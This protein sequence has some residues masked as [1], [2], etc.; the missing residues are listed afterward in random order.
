M[1]RYNECKTAHMEGYEN[2]TSKLFISLC[3]CVFVY[4]SVWVFA[5]CCWALAE[6]ECV[7]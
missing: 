3:V 1:N 6:S 2:V 7:E 5:A 4:S